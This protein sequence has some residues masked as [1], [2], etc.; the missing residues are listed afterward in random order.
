[1][2]LAGLTEGLVRD[3]DCDLD[4]D[5][6]IK[7]EPNLDEKQLYEAIL[8]KLQDEHEQKGYGRRE[9]ILTI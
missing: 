5:K 3:F 4:L 1:M 8:A 2:G 6:L 9:Y 7:D